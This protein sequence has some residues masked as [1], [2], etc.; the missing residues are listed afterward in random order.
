MIPVKTHQWV[1]LRS[2]SHILKAKGRKQKTRF[3]IVFFIEFA[4]K[5]YALINY[6]DTTSKLVA[7]YQYLLISI[8]FGEL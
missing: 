3:F 1:N 4:N 6:H 5:F 8:G 7:A 2:E